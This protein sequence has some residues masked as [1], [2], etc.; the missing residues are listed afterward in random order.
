MLSSMGVLLES[1]PVE[2]VHV[3]AA[4][5]GAELAASAALVADIRRDVE[6]LSLSAIEHA[7]LVRKCVAIHRAVAS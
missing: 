5:T 2:S 7:R 1:R 6:K 3:P 4:L